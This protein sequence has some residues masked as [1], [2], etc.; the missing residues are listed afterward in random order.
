MSEYKLFVAK[1]IKKLIYEKGIK[2][3]KMADDNGPGKQGPE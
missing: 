1:R 2:Q 3:S